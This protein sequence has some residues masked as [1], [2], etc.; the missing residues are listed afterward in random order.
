M[1]DFLFLLE[2]RLSLEQWQVVSDMEEA[3]DRVATN[4][5]LTGGAIR[6]LIAGLPIDDLDFV[7]EGK[8]SKLF[9]EL[10][11]KKVKILSENV[12]RQS[13]EFL[14]PSGAKTSVSMARPNAVEKQGRAAKAAVGTIISDL[15][16]RDFAMNSIAVSLNRYSRG[17]L[18][19]PA[20]GI[21]D[22]QNQQIRSLHNYVF[23]DQPVRLFRAVRFRARLGFEMDPKTAVQVENAV[24]EGLAEQV[25][26]E[27]LAPGQGH[28]Y[29][30]V[31]H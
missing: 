24:S 25:A 13:A 4:L 23:L 10:K 14:F 6:D 1:S 18:I 26:G 20:N 17:L 5:Y 29:T 19:D 22:I 9:R 31:A 8:I 15:K 28:L 30:R 12:R 2:S 16:S 21:A 3:A 27:S 7:L 11:K